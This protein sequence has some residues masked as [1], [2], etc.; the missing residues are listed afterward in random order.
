MTEEVVELSLC[1]SGL[2]CP[3]LNLSL[4]VHP[5]FPVQFVHG[6]Q[7]VYSVMNW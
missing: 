2:F 7:K 4:C 6:N 3:L 5:L 1:I